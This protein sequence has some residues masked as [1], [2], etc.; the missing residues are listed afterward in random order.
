MFV[1]M[2]L[3]NSVRVTKRNA[4]SWVYVTDMS[5]HTVLETST[6][7][8]KVPPSREGLWLPQSSKGLGVEQNLPGSFSK[9]INLIGEGKFPG[10]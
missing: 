6:S 10:T 2:V 4:L 3:P 5:A 7:K 1:T 9:G 8:I